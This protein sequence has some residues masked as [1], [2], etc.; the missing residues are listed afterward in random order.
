LEKLFSFGL[1]WFDGTYGVVLRMV[2]EFIQSLL[3]EIL[4][5]APFVLHPSRN[6]NL[7]T[8]IPTLIEWN[9]EWGEKIKEEH[10]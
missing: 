9:M 1:F 8:L 7:L 6:N 4:R 5:L 3:F 2:F 10:N